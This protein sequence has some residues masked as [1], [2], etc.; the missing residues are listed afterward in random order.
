[1]TTSDKDEILAA[2]ASLSDRL[3]TVENRLSAVEDNAAKALRMIERLDQKTNAIARKL[4][5]SG[6]LDVPH[7]RNAFSVASWTS[8]S[9]LA[10]SAGLAQGRDKTYAWQ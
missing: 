6:E 10:N 7:R 8:N 5:S 1:M 9:T 2:I 3:G 4:L